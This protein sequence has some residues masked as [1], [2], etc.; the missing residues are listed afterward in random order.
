MK[1]I[2]ERIWGRA[3]DGHSCCRTVLRKS[4]G[5]VRPAFDLRTDDVSPL[6]ERNTVSVLNI[7]DSW[8]VRM[9]LQ[10]TQGSVPSLRWAELQRAKLKAGLLLF[11]ESLPHNS[12]L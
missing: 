1:Y 10:L 2:K 7:S 11:C 5:A 8:Q 3:A 4:T 6:G 12:L 9:H